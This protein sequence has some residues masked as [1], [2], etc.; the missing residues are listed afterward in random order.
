[1]DII[2]QIV[3]I[4]EIKNG[5]LLMIHQSINVV[6]KMDGIVQVHICCSM[7]KRKLSDEE[8]KEIFTD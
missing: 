6:P 3:E 5:I 7:L 1:M 8:K 4:L 2:Q